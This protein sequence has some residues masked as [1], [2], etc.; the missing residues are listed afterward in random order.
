[1]HHRLA[2]TAVYVNLPGAP[3]ISKTSVKYIYLNWL[4]IGAMFSE[5]GCKVSWLFVW[6]FEVL[7]VPGSAKFYC[8]ANTRCAVG[9]NILE[10]GL[11][12]KR[13]LLKIIRCE[14]KFLTSK[15]LWVSFLFIFLNPVLTILNF[16]D[17]LT[18]FTSKYTALT[19]ISV[20]LHLPMWMK[21]SLNNRNQSSIMILV[22][23]RG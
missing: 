16:I 2:F 1:M 21:P 20:I 7:V 9:K 4:S 22:E 5:L 13:Q 14:I 10:L 6:A 3:E 12:G 19:L 23:G 17:D 11:A 18:R 8:A 15:T